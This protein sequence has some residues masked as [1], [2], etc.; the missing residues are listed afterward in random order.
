[1]HTHTVSGTAVDHCGHCGGL[2]FDATEL[3]QAWAAYRP[4]SPLHPE[5]LLPD[6]GYSGRDC[7]R[8]SRA[9]RTGGWTDLVLDRCPKCHGLFVEAHE[10]VRMRAEGIP[11]EPAS[12]A[13]RF[14]DRLVSIGLAISVAETIAM[15]LIHLWSK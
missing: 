3:D 10:L 6:R 12:F 4:R 5:R 15:L 8:C 11:L 9:L 1:M 14:R 13:S 2:W 7:P